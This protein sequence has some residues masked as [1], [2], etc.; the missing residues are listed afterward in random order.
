MH[1]SAK[2]YQIPTRSPDHPNRA[3]F[4]NRI[5]ACDE[6]Q[7]RSLG[8]GDDECVERVAREA[9]LIRDKHLLGC[10]IERLVRGITEQV[11]E[12]C[13]GAWPK[14]AAARRVKDQRMR[15]GNGALRISHA[16]SVIYRTA[17]YTSPCAHV[18]PRAGAAT[19]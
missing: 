4:A 15:I 17:P 9:M 6:R 14:A 2:R 1:P 8:G 19:C 16:A 10:D 13:G 18:P 7:P 5:V 12:Q 3:G 11:V